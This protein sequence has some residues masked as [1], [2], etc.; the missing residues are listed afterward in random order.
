MTTGQMF[1]TFRDTTDGKAYKISVQ[2]T[3]DDDDDDDD[4]KRENILLISGINFPMQLLR[5]ILNEL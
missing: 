1:Y 5:S 3:D 4:Y 2:S